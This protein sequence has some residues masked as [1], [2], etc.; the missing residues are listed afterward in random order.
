[1]VAAGRRRATDHSS[2]SGLLVAPSRSSARSFPRLTARH[3][4]A[5]CETPR[6]TR[7]GI[8]GV[9]ALVGLDL[10]GDAA[11][12]L[13]MTL[14]R[15]AGTLSGPLIG[16][17]GVWPIFP[18]LERGGDLA[19]GASALL[20]APVGIAQLP[21]TMPS[22]S[23]LTAVAVLGVVCTAW[24]TAFLPAD[25]GGRAPCGRSNRL[26]SIPRS[27][28]SQA[29]CCSRSPSPSGQRWPSSSSWR[30]HGCDRSFGSGRGA[31][32]GPAAGLKPGIACEVRQRR[33]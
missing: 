10:S 21:A 17:R 25:S 20:Y 7:S 11:A 12:I 6:R 8:R 24:H 3:Q 1:V 32:A 28:C 16:I 23:V 15:G 33:P 31:A 14:G 13:E 27:R 9:V 18:T 4:P 29:S 2:L 26:T 5:R 22:P 30:V 19:R